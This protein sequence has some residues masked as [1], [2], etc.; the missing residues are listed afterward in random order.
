MDATPPS[1]FLSFYSVTTY[2]Y[3]NKLISVDFCKKRQALGMHSRGILLCIV[4][5]RLAVEKG[6]VSLRL[7]NEPRITRLLPLL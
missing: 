3:W 2:Y 4:P 7:E 5:L 1:P 6:A